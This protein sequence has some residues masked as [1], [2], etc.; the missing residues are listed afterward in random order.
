VFRMFQRLHS[1]SNYPGT[2][3]GLA[4]CKRIA[5]RHNGRI[6]VGVNHPHGAIM[7]VVLP[8]KKSA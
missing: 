3:L 2:G 6:Q 7:T 8:S 4:L 1:R 5:D